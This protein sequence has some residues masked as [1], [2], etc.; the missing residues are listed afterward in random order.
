MKTTEEKAKESVCVSICS[1][2]IA[3]GFGVPDRQ[4][5]DAILC[6]IY[7]TLYTSGSKNHRSV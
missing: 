7:N 6:G 4:I 1:H 5:F 3:V 2:L